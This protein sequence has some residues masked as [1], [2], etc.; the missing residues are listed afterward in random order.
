MK[1]L[2]DAMLGKL[3]HFLRIFGYDTVYADEL[4]T[5]FN[6][7]P[8][9]DDKLLEYA[10][11]EN[12][13]IITKDLP[14]YNKIRANSVLLKG[15]GVYNYLNQLKLKLNLDYQFQIHRARCSICNSAL[16]KVTKKSNI[17]EEVLTQTYNNYD[18]FYQ[19]SNPDCGKIYWNGPH[20]N[21]ILNKIKKKQ[22][23]S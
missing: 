12:R 10:E 19:C 1:F 6:M 14:F 21:D 23:W 7:T 18:E 20:I 11:K 13:I 16:E 2:V 4:E 9:S 3:V 8:V 22:K 15:E 5:Y 17:K